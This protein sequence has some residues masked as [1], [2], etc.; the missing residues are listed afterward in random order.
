MAIQ[1]YGKALEIQQ[2]E[3]CAIEIWNIIIV[4]KL[5][6]SR[7]NSNQYTASK[8]VCSYLHAD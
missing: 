5:L 4:P 8:T 1:S 2:G 7:K 6:D 3:P